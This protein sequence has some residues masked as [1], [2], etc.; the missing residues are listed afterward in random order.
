M[1]LEGLNTTEWCFL[2][3]QIKEVLIEVMDHRMN[4]KTYTVTVADQAR[5]KFD[6]SF[7]LNGGSIL[8]PDY[9]KKL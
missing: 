2:R 4:G 7:D 8:E 3:M 1:I 6:L 5:Q 9:V